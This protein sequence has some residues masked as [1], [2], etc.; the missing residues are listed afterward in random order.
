[1]Q[2]RRQPT[3]TCETAKTAPRAQCVAMSAHIKKIN[4][5][6]RE[7]SGDPDLNYSKLQFSLGHTF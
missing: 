7:K 1:M 6:T 5:Q 3:K 4:K 2:I